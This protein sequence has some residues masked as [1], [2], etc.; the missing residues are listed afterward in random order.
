MTF[1]VSPAE[2]QALRDM[3]T[4][5]PVAEDYGADVLIPGNGF[6]LGVQRKVFPGDFLSSL[7][8]GRLSTSLVKL[9]KCEVRVLILEG[10]QNWT[11][12]GFLVSDY[13][14]FSRTQL[15]NLLMSA[16]F[17][18]GVHTIAT[19]SLMD[20]QDV[21][22]DLVRWAAK[23]RHD[24]LFSRPGG[25][26]PHKRVWS[27]RDKGLFMLQGIEGVGPELA[28][29]IYDHFGRL[30]LKWDCDIEEL[31]AIPD[32][33]GGRANMVW[34]AVGGVLSDRDRGIARLQDIEGVGPELAVRIYDHF[35]RLPRSTDDLGGIEGIGKV[36]AERL[37]K[38][39][40]N[41]ST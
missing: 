1:L 29:R 23:D 37:R 18:L 19:D 24:S 38:V 14:Q 12:S 27:N 34:Q 4:S 11:T 26:D 40:G 36:K 35:G 41:G 30:P 6:F 7:Y 22:R 33:G 8:D 9:S 15:R 25:K 17:E 21:L 13:Q 32:F 16:H 3:G 31:R 2:P 5:A 28:G 10:R 20:T 39:M